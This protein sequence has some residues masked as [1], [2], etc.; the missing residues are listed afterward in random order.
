MSYH[1]PCLPSTLFPVR[2][3]P[4]S[5][6]I[7]SIHPPRSMLNHFPC[8]PSTLLPVR[9][10]P[11]LPIYPLPPSTHPVPCSAALLVPSHHFHPPRSPFHRPPLPHP[12]S[13]LTLYPLLLSIFLPVS[14]LPLFLIQY[15]QS[16]TLFLV[17][18]L[19]LTTIH[20]FHP[21]QSPVHHIFPLIHYFHPS[22]PLFH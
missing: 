10:L 5:L 1:F 14:P 3:L 4:Y 17:P 22:H 19:P 6:S 9:P 12:L 21:L 11:F 16:S 20:Y 2:P 8:L 18:P 7:T 13:I 15:F